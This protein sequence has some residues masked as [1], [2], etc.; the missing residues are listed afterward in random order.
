MKRPGSLSRS[1]M[2]RRTSPIARTASQRKPRK[3]S[4]FARIYHSRERVRFVATMPCLVRDRMCDGPI[5]NAHTANGGMGRKAGYETVVPLCR[6]HHNQLHHV[7]AETFQRGHHVTL[8]WSAGSVEALWQRALAG[9]R[10][11]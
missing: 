2:P 10:S 3:P 8:A 11:A 4:E 9:E 5:Q 6:W 7:G 1:P